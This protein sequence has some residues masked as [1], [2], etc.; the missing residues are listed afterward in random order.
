[1]KLNTYIGGDKL[2]IADQCYNILNGRTAAYLAEAQKVIVL[3]E[4]L[5]RK[6]KYNIKQ[7]RFKKNIHVSDYHKSRR[8]LVDMKKAAYWYN[9]SWTKENGEKL[10]RIYE[11]YVI[12]VNEI[13]M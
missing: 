9:H 4:F 5:L 10:Y 1:M 7:I 13:C 11:R 12:S 8:I 6:N 3:S 2:D